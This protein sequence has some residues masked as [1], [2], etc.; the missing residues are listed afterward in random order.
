MLALNPGF[1]K[2]G[3]DLFFGAFDIE[4]VLIPHAHVKEFTGSDEFA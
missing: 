3:T 2:T 4:N 1:R